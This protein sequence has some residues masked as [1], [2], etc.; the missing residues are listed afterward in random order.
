MELGNKLLHAR[1]EAGLS[2]RQLCEGIVTRNM[3]SQIE[4][5]TARPSMD[6][7][8]ALATR[9]GKPLSWFLDED[10]LRSPN[11]EVIFAAREALKNRQFSAL[12]VALENYQSPD[13]VFD[14]ERELLQLLG[15]LGKAEE[16]VCS[17]QLPYARELLAQT[18]V[19]APPLYHIPELERRR[20]LLLLRTEA[21]NRSEL[22]ARLPSPDTEL[23]LRAEV[24]L[25]EGDPLRCGQLLDAA[26]QRDPR[27]YLL[28]GQAD[29]RMGRYR[30]G[31]E[32]LHKAEDA[33]PAETA[34][35]L[36]LCYRELEDYKQAYFYARKQL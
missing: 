20:T 4:H 17:D 25:E 3:L 33:F 27:W 30:E 5:G 35:L 15:I 13:P 1:L 21:R 23:M 7:L 10:A 6:T 19:S 34:A 16:A 22:L 2:Q 14:P 12:L 29:C 11:Q 9:L 36:E 24:A 8:R 28:R 26:Q 32:H 18:E 31:A